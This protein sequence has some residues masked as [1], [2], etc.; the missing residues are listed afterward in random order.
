MDLQGLPEVQGRLG[1]QGLLALLD[2]QERKEIL[3]LRALKA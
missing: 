2:L 3:A 1:L